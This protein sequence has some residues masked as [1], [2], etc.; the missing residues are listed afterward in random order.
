MIAGSSLADQTEVP[1]ATLADPNN[2]NR[3]SSRFIEDG[4]YIRLKELAVSYT[5]PKTV[6]ERLRISN[7]K[8]FVSAYN[9]LT[10]TNYSG[11]DPEIN[12]AGNDNLRIGTDFFTYPQSRRFMIGLNVGF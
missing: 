3:H 4:S 2:N 12:Y 7:L 8:L 6:I 10:F 9:L 1:R 5:F 11:M